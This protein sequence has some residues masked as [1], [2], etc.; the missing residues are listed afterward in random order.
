[1]KRIGEREMRELERRER[2]RERRRARSEGSS[3][4]RDIGR[5]GE[6]MLDGMG[7]WV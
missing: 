1:M 4:E 5:A 2:R 6:E 3:S 7:K